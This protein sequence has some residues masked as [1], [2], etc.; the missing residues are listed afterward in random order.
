MLLFFSLRNRSY[1]LCSFFSFFF[2]FLAFLSLPF[3]IKV[4]NHF[5]ASESDDYA[6][7]F[8]YLFILLFTSKPQ[9]DQLEPLDEQVG[10]TNMMG[11][12]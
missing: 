10:W 3:E 6:K 4:D 5:A 1:R 7:C 11:E 2:F 8:W 9:T 12:R